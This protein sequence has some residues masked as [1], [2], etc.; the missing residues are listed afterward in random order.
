MNGTAAV[1]N[2]RPFTCS[3]YCNSHYV[4][5]HRAYA[6]EYFESTSTINSRDD[7]LIHNAKYP[8]HLESELALRIL[9]LERHLK[10]RP[11]VGSELTALL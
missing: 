6:M 9:V 3:Y 5:E 10:F 2:V 11:S 4:L 7:I 1:N 8:P